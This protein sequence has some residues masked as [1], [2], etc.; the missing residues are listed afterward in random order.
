MPGP[1]NKTNPQ[2][3]A[4][5]EWWNSYVN[6]PKYNQRLAGFYKY[7]GYIQNQ[8]AR[9][10]GETTFRENQGTGTQYYPSDNEVAVS[11]LQINALR[12]GRDEV[13]AHELGHAV[14][15][16]NSRAL[17]LSPSEARYIMSR[18][19]N[20]SPAEAE[21]FMKSATEKGEKISDVMGGE[22]HDVTPTESMSDINAF[23]Y[24]LNKRKIYD[25]GTQDVT[26]DVLKKAAKDPVIRKSFIYRRLKEN[27]EEDKLQE[28]MNRVASNKR[29]KQ[30]NIA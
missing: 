4:A 21:S 6:S 17:A 9:V 11:P 20:L 27:F 8:R 14:N 29:V 25:A 13:V 16:G 18:N 2:D 30:S 3:K 1:K 24:L 12:A 7:P 15:A 28:I 19:K 22:L 23:R 26:P 5:A 10:L